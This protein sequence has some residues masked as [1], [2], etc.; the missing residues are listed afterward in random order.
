MYGIHFNGE[1]EDYVE[2]SGY[3][4]GVGE[5]F[6]KGGHDKSPVGLVLQYMNRSCRVCLANPDPDIPAH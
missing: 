1:K 5:I 3:V 4:K 2:D 6:R